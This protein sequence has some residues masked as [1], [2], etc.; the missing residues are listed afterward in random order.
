MIEPA[1]P[2]AKIKP[3]RMY[4]L[5]AVLSLV[6]NS[7]GCTDF[8]MTVT[9]S[10]GYIAQFPP[11]VI[12]WLDSAPTWTTFAWGLGTWGA[13]AGSLMLLARSR[14]AVEAFAASL[15]GL[16]M[17]QAWQFA[18]DLPESMTTTTDTMISVIIWVTAI[19]LFA[20]ALL[21]RRRGVLH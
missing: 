1:D 8:T 5:I 14:W 19:V 11:E 4:W 6:W 12:D 20:Y 13:L 16:A 21:M 15:A 9:R 17:T 10:P 18:D 7:I 2:N 3:S